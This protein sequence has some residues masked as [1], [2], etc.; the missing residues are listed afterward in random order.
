MIFKTVKKNNILDYL[1]AQKFKQQEFYN[2][3]Y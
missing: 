3:I 2:N 1:K